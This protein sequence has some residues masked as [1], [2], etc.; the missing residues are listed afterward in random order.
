[1]IA[2]TKKAFKV[3]PELDGINTLKSRIAVPEIKEVPMA[4]P[5][6]AALTKALTDVSAFNQMNIRP[7]AE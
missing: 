6:S 3:I 1:M 5:N 7:P 4:K 2:K